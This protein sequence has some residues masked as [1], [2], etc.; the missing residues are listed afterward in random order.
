[1]MVVPLR[2]RTKSRDCRPWC[3]EASKELKCGEGRTGGKGRNGKTRSMERR[4]SMERKAMKL[5]ID[6]RWRRVIMAKERKGWAWEWWQRVFASEEGKKG[7]LTMLHGNKV[8]D[9]I[10]FASAPCLFCHHPS[11]SSQ[12][13]CFLHF[14][15]LI[16]CATFPSILATTPFI[17]NPV[18]NSYA[19][20]SFRSRCRR[21]TFAFITDKTS[22]FHNDACPHAKTQP[23]PSHAPYFHR[24]LPFATTCTPFHLTP[25]HISLACTL[26]FH[27]CQ[28]PRF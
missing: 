24:R 12:A 1:M 17:S 6:D 9:V 18:H 25:A 27:F 16:N 8:C 5:G 7:E 11:A 2:D 13:S 21:S 14:C 3:C 10:A 23:F 26:D 28:L 20:S 4:K 19:L 22:A 15:H